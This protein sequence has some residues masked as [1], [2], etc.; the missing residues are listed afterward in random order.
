MKAEEALVNIL[1]RQFILKI[2]DTYG[3][4]AID[5]FK[6]CI[7]QLKRLYKAIDLNQYESIVAFVG[8][9]GEYQSVSK[10]MMIDNIH[11]VSTKNL[12]VNFV[13]ADTIMWYNMSALMLFHYQRRLSFID[14][15]PV[16]NRQTSSV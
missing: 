2:D 9:C 8:C 5:D 11:S 4:K 12:V 13:D 16:R 7:S 15:V 10:T 3:D 14:G 1:Q 6:L